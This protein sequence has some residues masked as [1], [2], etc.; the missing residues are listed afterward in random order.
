MSETLEEAVDQHANTSGAVRLIK[1]LTPYLEYEGTPVW[2]VPLGE[3]GFSALVAGREGKGYYLRHVAEASVDKALDFGDI[4]RE[5]TPSPVPEVVIPLRVT[6]GH[7]RG[8]PS[9]Y[10]GYRLH[11]PHHRVERVADYTLDLA[12]LGKDLYKFRQDRGW[13]V[14]D[15]VLQVGMAE[16]TWFRMEN[17]RNVKPTAQTVLRMLKVLGVQDY[18]QYLI[19]EGEDE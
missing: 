6:D 13:T 7:D 10:Q 4:L 17:C 3:D 19:K 14:A 15:T 12:A 2:E 5:E 11:K 1:E 9:T 18:N 16:D 8:V